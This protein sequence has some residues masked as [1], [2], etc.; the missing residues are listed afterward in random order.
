[1]VDERC[2][3]DGWGLLRNP[4]EDKVT[5]RIIELIYRCPKC[6]RAYSTIYERISIQGERLFD[7]IGVIGR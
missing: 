4:K 7:K 5:E 1:M 2:P 6:K 3:R